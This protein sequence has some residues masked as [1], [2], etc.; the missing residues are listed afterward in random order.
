M[1]FLEDLNIG[2]ETCPPAEAVSDIYTVYRLVESVPIKIED[3]WSYRALFP[4]KVFKVDE[5]IARSCSV[6]TECEDL[7]NLQKIP[8]FRKRVII[9]INIKENDGVLLKTFKDSHWSWWISKKFDLAAVK[10]VYNET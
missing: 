8:K 9:L 2:G 5:C 7:K 10:E 4:T 6:Y 1:E 3:V